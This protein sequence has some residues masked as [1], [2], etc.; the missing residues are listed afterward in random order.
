[1]SHFVALISLHV[2]NYSSITSIY[3]IAGKL[4]LVAF[5]CDICYEI[6]V[7]PQQQIVH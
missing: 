3:Y 7:A 2:S 5:F 6:K 4:A 1:M